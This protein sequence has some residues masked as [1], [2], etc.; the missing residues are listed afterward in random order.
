MDNFVDTEHCLSKAHCTTCRDLVGGYQW[1][2]SLK[3]LFVLPNDQIDF[4]CPYG[5]KW[6]DEGMTPKMT[7]A[8]TGKVPEAAAQT[9]GGCGCS[10]RAAT[11]KGRQR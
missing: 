10:R 4:E 11:R 1:R 7:T 3:S 9:E 5:K 8:A 2:N 6:G